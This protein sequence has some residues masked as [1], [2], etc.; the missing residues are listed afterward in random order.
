MKKLKFFLLSFVL[1]VS[2]SV[3]AKVKYIQAPPLKSVINKSVKSCGQLSTVQVPL[4]TWGGDIATVLANGGETKT[5]SKSIFGKKNLNLKLVREDVFS[6]QVEN[7]V[8]CKSPFIRGTMGMVNL[9]SEVTEKDPR[10]KMKIIY[11]LTWSAGGDAMVVKSTVNGPKDLKG[12]TI[13]LQAYGPHVDYLAKILSDAGL[14][15]KDVNIKWVKDLTGTAN[16]PVEAFRETGID[17][18]MVIIPDALAL[19]SNGTVGTGSEDSVKGARVLLSTKTANRVISDVYA[20]RSDF[21]EANKDLVFNFVSG[22]YKAQE[23]LSSTMKNEKSKQYATLMGSAAKILLDSPQAIADTKGMYLDAE[24][25]GYVGNQKFF[26]DLAWPR[27]YKSL[28]A[29]IQKSYIDLGLISSPT[30]IAWANFNFNELKSGLRNTV[31]KDTPKF[32]VSKVQN[33]VTQ[34]SAL[35]T[36]DSDALFALKAFFQANAVNFDAS[37]YTK[38]FNKAVK[39]M[40]TYGGALL[41][42][43]GHSD[44]SNFERKK[45]KGATQLVLSRIRQ[46]AKN[47]SLSRANAF[48]SSLISYAKAKGIAIDPS[49]IVAIGHGVNNPVYARPKTK[50][51]WAANRRIEFRIVNVE[52]ESDVFV[53][54]E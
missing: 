37:N 49:Q 29:E 38:E 9:A 47:L 11:Q 2:T 51:Q 6:R 1:L 28:T 19:T 18:A 43:E 31:A 41:T 46:A 26:T 39:L 25:S 8:T 54:F 34:K 53:P 14:T 32:D 24:F 12:K 42:V 50:Q 44:P 15:F 30:T 35:G 7:F 48:R 40:S 27:N 36:L 52:A 21:Y 5:S 22:L 3:I 17:A 4:I 20:V 33:V 10:T 13:A 23:E 45:E 16:T